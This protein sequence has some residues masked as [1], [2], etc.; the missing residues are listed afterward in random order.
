VTAAVLLGHAREA[1]QPFT[2][3]KAELVNEWVSHFCS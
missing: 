3:R 2:A 1:A